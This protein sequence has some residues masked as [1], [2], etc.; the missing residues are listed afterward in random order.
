MVYFSIVNI[1]LNCHFPIQ[2]HVNLPV[3]AYNPVVSAHDAKT[4]GI[5]EILLF[6]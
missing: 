2:Q 4:L 5:V 1:N 3:Q 6:L